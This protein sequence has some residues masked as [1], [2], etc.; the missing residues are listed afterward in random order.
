MR[1]LRFSFRP[2]MYCGLLMPVFL[3]AVPSRPALAQETAQRTAPS[4][5]VIGRAVAAMDALFR[6]N[7]YQRT[8]KA[9]GTGGS[10]VTA[11]GW[12]VKVEGDSLLFVDFERSANFKTHGTKWSQ[13]SQIT[14]Y[15]LPIAQLASARVDSYPTEWGGQAARV[16]GL[17]TGGALVVRRV[18]DHAS[19]PPA[20]DPLHEDTMINSVAL[21]EPDAPWLGQL[22]QLFKVLAGQV[23]PGIIPGAEAPE[24]LPWPFPLD[25]EIDKEEPPLLKGRELGEA[26]NVLNDILEKNT[27]QESG[28]L[29]AS[30]KRKGQ[31]VSY[32]Q[33]GPVI[34]TEFQEEQVAANGQIVLATS[35][36]HEEIIDSDAFPT[37]FV[38]VRK[39]NQGA[40]DLLIFLFYDAEVAT[41]RQTYTVR[42][43][44]GAPKVTESNSGQVRIILPDTPWA[45]EFVTVLKK[46]C[47]RLDR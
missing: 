31:F 40:R 22:T 46:I 33:G 1:P 16:V 10:Q 28:N 30:A 45:Q 47:P 41:M 4:R 7:L 18:T 38:E 6:K 37:A 26:I 19:D 35:D 20:G 24:D 17:V 21:T 8:A 43:N 32:D 3:V 29:Q 15:D 14:T 11:K 39:S 36:V 34:F 5:E 25:A 27:Y 9:S 2:F 23:A 12:R 44:G 13:S 42:P